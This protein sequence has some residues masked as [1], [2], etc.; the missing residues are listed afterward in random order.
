M[1]HTPENLRRL[2]DI[3][4]VRPKLK[5]AMRALGCDE[6]LIFVWMNKSAQGDP[7]FLIDWPEGEPP[8]QLV[9]QIKRARAMNIMGLDATFRGTAGCVVSAGRH[10]TIALQRGHALHHFHKRRR[11]PLAGAAQIR[12]SLPNR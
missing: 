9:E 3:I 1:K 4:S 12:G 5:P 2:L 6:T 8:L 11:H 10:K 7:R